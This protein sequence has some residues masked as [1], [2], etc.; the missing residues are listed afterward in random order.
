[1]RTLALL[2]LV[3]TSCNSDPPSPVDAGDISDAGAVDTGVV[4]V[5]LGTDL[6]AQDTGT[7]AGTPIDLGPADTGADIPMDALPDGCASATVGNCCGI[8]CPV[9]A[10]ASSAVCN[11]GRCA[12][13]GCNTGFGDCDGDGANGCETN[14]GTAAAHCGAC[15]APCGEGRSCVAGACIVRCPAGFA[16][17]DNNAMNGCEVNLAATNAHCG[18]CNN[19]CPAGQVC[20]G[21]GTC[22]TRCIAGYSN[23]P[24]TC[25][26]CPSGCVNTSVDLMHCG[27][28]RIACQPFNRAEP[29][30]S[31]SRCGI[32]CQSGWANCDNDPANGCEAELRINQQNCGSCRRVCPAGQQCVDS[33]CVP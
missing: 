27:G 32:R 28:C 26:G 21:D 5:D 29:T 30:C 7:D 17:C 1:M 15:G 18:V 4:A 12:V 19:A 2:A 6:G 3:L 23:C 10:N 16:D 33:N 24:G 8:A 11:G 20:A 9:P 14:T 22:G 31:N 13:G 25:S